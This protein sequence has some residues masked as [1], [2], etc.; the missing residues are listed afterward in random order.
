MAN[1]VNL[2][3]LQ[4][5]FNKI[6][7]KSASITPSYTG[8]WTI[9]FM[10]DKHETYNLTAQRGEYRQFKTIDSAFQLCHK[11]GFENV[12]IVKMI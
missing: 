4:L 8:N 2:K 10:D 1:K 5:L 7:I 3:E 6:V 11:I 12:E 9:I